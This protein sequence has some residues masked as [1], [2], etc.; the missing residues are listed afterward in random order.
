MRERVRGVLVRRRYGQ[1][2]RLP[3]GGRDDITGR[4]PV[5][6]GL[7]ENRSFSC[8]LDASR[9]V[10]RACHIDIEPDLGPTSTAPASPN[11]STVLDFTVQKS[12]FSIPN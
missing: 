6:M 8:L 11:L 7:D 2:E 9:F 10:N 3:G 4:R 12:N 5:A 1:E